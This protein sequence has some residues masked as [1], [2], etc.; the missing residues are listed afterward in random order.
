M[1][2]E[3]AR[4]LG[5]EATNA[6]DR[7]ATP[8]T[9]A[10]ADLTALPARISRRDRLQNR[11]PLLRRY[12]VVGLG[13]VVV[14]AAVYALLVALTGNTLIAKPI[15]YVCGAL[16]SYLGNWR[17]TFGLRR[18]KLSEVAFVLVY[19]TSLGVNLGINEALLALLPEAWWRSPL[20]FFVSTS[21]TTV[22][23]FVG[24]SLFV[25]KERDKADSLKL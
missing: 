8:S 13:S 21:I 14:D 1:T 2:D 18:S 23:N 4:N 17:F 5:G 25:F 3:S 10:R 24:Q 11:L 16:F 20:A 15:S 6:I 12:L 9:T 7:P 19:V 22:W